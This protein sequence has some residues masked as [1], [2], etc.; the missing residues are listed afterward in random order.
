MPYLKQFFIGGSNS[1]RAFRNGTLG[2]GS[3]S[4]SL[5]TSQAVQ[6]GEIKFEYNSELRLKVMKYIY[7]AVF[8]DVGNIWYRKEQPDAPGSG[9]S[10]NWHKELAVDAGLGLRIDANIMV[11][12]FDVAI[13]LRIPSLP[14]D[15]RWVVDDVNIG[16]KQWRKDNVILNIA[17][18]YPF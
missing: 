18:G 9:F 14:E 5:I 2:P 16:S 3:Y 8:T 15:Q 6:A 4:D 17:F 7:T 1:L 12:R 10:R 13:P 11:I